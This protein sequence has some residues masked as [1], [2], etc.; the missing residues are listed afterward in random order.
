VSRP[1]LGGLVDGTLYECR[2]ELAK[3]RK[4]RDAIFAA[5]RERAA[6]VA[7]DCMPAAPSSQWRAAQ[8]A[9][10]MAIRALELEPKVPSG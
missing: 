3:V 5:T 8:V 10:A 6:K 7:D 2:V 1:E 4:E 9:I